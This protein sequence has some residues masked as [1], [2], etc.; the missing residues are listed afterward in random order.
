MTA[1]LSL[2]ARTFIIGSATVAIAVTL[3]DA[4]PLATYDFTGEAAP[5]AQIG[6]INATSGDPNVTASPI[7]ITPFPFVSGNASMIVANA[8]PFGGSAPYLSAFPGAGSTTGATAT[9][10]NQ[11]FEFAVTAA[12]GYELD[13][14]SL[15]FNATKG[16]TG[17]RGFVLQTSVGGFST[18]GST[19][20]DNVI[21]PTNGTASTPYSYDFSG[22]AYQNLSSFTARFYIFAPATGNSVNFDDFVLN[23]SAVAIPEPTIASIATVCL[24]GLARRRRKVKS[25]SV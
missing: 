8:V 5:T 3:T 11:Y 25:S 14:T 4:A 15:T 12:S 2:L 9:A 24:A 17:D 16:N 20:L 13:L 22:P 1:D 7:T 18:D 10:N 21:V 23:G 19:N 6:S